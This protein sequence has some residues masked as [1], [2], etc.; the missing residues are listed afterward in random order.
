MIASVI[1]QVIKY[2]IFN[3]VLIE[4][5]GKSTSLIHVWH[6]SYE[7][8]HAYG[9]LLFPVILLPDNLMQV[10][11]LFRAVLFLRK[12]LFRAILVKVTLGISP[13]IRFQC[14]D[15]I[16]YENVYVKWYEIFEIY[17]LKWIFEWILMIFSLKTSIKALN[18]TFYSRINLIIAFL[19]DISFSNRSV[20]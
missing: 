12:T 4:I 18:R 8:F 5:V 7:K 20:L 14:K 19:Y 3:T 2:D 11:L 1:D 6:N 16:I 17:C 15:Q 9:T 10:I 13:G